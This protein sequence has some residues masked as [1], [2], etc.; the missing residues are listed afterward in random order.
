MVYPAACR[1]FETVPKTEG[2]LW[3]HFMGTINAGWPV[4]RNPTD[5]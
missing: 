2:C 4:G 3:P 1:Q 5:P